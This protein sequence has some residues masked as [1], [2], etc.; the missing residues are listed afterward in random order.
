MTDVWLANPKC[1]WI[2]RVLGV[3]PFS[4]CSV[5]MKL[6]MSCCRSVSMELVWPN[7][8]RVASSNEHNVNDDLLTRA[9]VS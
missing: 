8:E 3:I 4:R 1:F 5:W 6:R 9:L 2:S 7:E